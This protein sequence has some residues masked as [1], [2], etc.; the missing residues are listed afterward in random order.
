MTLVTTPRAAQHRTLLSV[1]AKFACNNTAHQ[2]EEGKGD[3]MKTKTIVCFLMLAGLLALSAP[4]FA[5]HGYAGYDMQI[6]RYVK[7]TI[8]YFMIV[9]PHGQI[10][11]DVKDDSGN[12]EHWIM[13]G[14]ANPRGM[15]EGGWEY[16]SLKPGDEV[17]IYYHPSKT[18]PH[19]GVFIKV[20]FPDG[21]ILPKS[22]AANAAGQTGQTP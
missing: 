20:I 22:E 10:G 18:G 11:I 1:R 3:A 21:H 12:V 14:G 6:T 17:T 13:E 9:N 16:D 4:T 19:A 15:K 7:G 5:H 8:T 2:L